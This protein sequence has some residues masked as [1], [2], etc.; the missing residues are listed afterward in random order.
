MSALAGIYSLNLR[1]LELLTSDYGDK[2]EYGLAYKI[3]PKLRGSLLEESLPDTRALLAVRP[4]KTEGAV[5]G[6]PDGCELIAF[7]EAVW[8]VRNPQHM[9]LIK[10]LLF[11][12]LRNR[13]L[14]PV[15]RQDV[16]LDHC[17]IRVVQGKGGKD[18]SV[19]FPISFRGS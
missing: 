2:G 11:T 10:L 6:T 7:Y 13:E 17:Q 15:R 4:T 8:Q 9:V 12:G 16:D 18:R 14:A 19:L 1:L 3:S 5:P